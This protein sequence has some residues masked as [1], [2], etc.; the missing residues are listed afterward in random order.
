MEGEILSHGIQEKL[1]YIISQS[2]LNNLL[3]IHFEALEGAQSKL[4]HKKSGDIQEIS[5]DD[6][7]VA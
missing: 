5:F 2:A 7:L 3:D 1:F 4:V 6:L